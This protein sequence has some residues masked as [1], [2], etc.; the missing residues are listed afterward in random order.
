[1]N[2]DWI[3]T[4][5][6][7]VSAFVLGGLWYSPLLFGRRW[8]ADNR[9]TEAQAAADPARVFGTAFVF[10]LISA[11]VFGY[12][13]QGQQTLAATLQAGVLIGLGLV[14]ASFGLS[15]AFERRPLS[16]L[17]ING[18]YHTAQFTLYGLIFGLL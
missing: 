18:G 11:I 17:A 2:I 10:T 13:M 9:L 5:V 4:L 16:L 12:Y 6:S 1:M 14:A 7:A 3:A 8:M 15:Y